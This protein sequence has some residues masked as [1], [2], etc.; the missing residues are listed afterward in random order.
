[1]KKGKEEKTKSR[2]QSLDKTT[3]LLEKEGLVHQGDSTP[4]ARQGVDSAT[5][6]DQLQRIGLLRKD[7]WTKFSIFCL[8]ALKIRRGL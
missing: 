2:S 6:S 8:T 3:N 7:C 4:V 5:V 1:M